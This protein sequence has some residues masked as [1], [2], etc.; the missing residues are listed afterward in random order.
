[1]SDKPDLFVLLLSLPAVLPDIFGL[2]ASPLLH[3]A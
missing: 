1:M 2:F 3:E